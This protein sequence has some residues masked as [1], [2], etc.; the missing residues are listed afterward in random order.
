MRRRSSRSLRGSRNSWRRIRR[1]RRGRYSCRSMPGIG[2]VGRTWLIGMLPELGD[3]DRRQIAALAGVAP[4]PHQSGGP[5]R[6]LF[7]PVCHGVHGPPR[8]GVQEGRDCRREQDADAAVRDGPRWP[9]VD[10]NAGVPKR[11]S[12]LTPLTGD[13]VATEA[14]FCR[15][16]TWIHPC[17]TPTK[18]MR[19]QCQWPHRAAASV[20][21]GALGRSAPAWLRIQRVGCTRSV[22]VR[23]KRRHRAADRQVVPIAR[24]RSAGTVLPS[25]SGSAAGAPRSA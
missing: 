8:E 15:G 19:I 10:R 13:T 21:W 12:R 9:A 14:F 2:P 20:P 23:I 6:S 3:L 22:L 24:Q 18:R 7:P 1:C 25:R 11:P 5:T 17:T 16:P 4:H